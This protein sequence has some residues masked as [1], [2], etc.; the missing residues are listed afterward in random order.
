M[1]DATATVISSLITGVS[2]VLVT[3]VGA[4]VWD[5]R[6]KTV[7]IRDQVENDHDTNFREDFDEKHNENNKFNE[8]ILEAVRTLSGDVRHTNQKLDKVNEKVDNTNDKLERTNQRVDSL[9]R[10][11]VRH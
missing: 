5:I 11:Y 4:L 9:W 8:L 6:R 2:G 7:R 1:N 3:I 10:K